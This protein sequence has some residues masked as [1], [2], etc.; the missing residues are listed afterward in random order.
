MVSCFNL[1][2]H[3][4]I[5]SLIVRQGMHFDRPASLCEDNAGEPLW[6]KTVVLEL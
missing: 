4:G 1:S 2:A 6:Q 5:T 3:S